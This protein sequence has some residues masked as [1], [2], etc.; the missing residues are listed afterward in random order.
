MRK[1]Y[2][3]VYTTLILLYAAWWIEPSRNSGAK[4]PIDKLHT[5]PE[6]APELRSL[7]PQ[8][9]WAKFLQRGQRIVSGGLANKT[10]SPEQFASDVLALRH[11][12][13]RHGQSLLASAYVGK[14][15]LEEHAQVVWQ[16]KHGTKAGFHTRY[17]K[18]VDPSWSEESPPLLP[19]IIGLLKFWLF[20]I[21]FAGTIL[22]L[23]AAT[24]VRRLTELIAVIQFEWQEFLA[25]TVAWPFGL[26]YYCPT[27]LS[28]RPD[29]TYLLSKKIV[30]HRD[31]G[32]AMSG[33]QAREEYYYETEVV[34]V[35]FLDGAR[36][37]VRIW[38]ALAQPNF[39]LLIP[40]PWSRQWRVAVYT[41]LVCFAYLL[42]EQAAAWAAEAKDRNDFDLTQALLTVIK[43][44]GKPSGESL[45]LF[46]RGG[47]ELHVFNM[48]DP[49]PS[50]ELS[51]NVLR[52]KWKQGSLVAGP[53]VGYQDNRMS[54]L[55]EV[56]F[57]SLS[58]GKQ[59]K[60]TLPHYLMLSRPS[61]LRFFTPDGRLHFR[62]NKNWGVGVGFTTSLSPS[63]RDTFLL[64][65]SI[66]GPVGRRAKFHLRFGQWLKHPRLRG[67][68]QLRLDVACSF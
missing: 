66:A 39:T 42:S 17:M 20:F 62:P 38:T 57:L 67:N 50:V 49:H 54:H 64:G 61:E 5:A 18:A 10:Y 37:F 28:K 68:R 13:Y 15:E 4:G 47:T 11:E 32:Y 53:F 63:K 24:G 31:S 30:T 29:G 12:T 19:L 25:A 40:K 21:P 2:Y 7:S 60:L 22:L 26:L 48:R 44:D 33:I 45:R 51:Q 34:D 43:P 35:R 55:G 59:L 9:R 56:G 16:A 3:L 46:F 36:E 52:G 6:I 65:P 58:P 8:A 23:R 41:C 27:G 14:N 1:L